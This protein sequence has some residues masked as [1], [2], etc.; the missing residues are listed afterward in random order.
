[1]AITGD[2]IPL[3][4]FTIMCLQ[5]KIYSGFF[6]NK[7]YLARMSGHFIANRMSKGRFPAF[8]Y[9]HFHFKIIQMTHTSIALVLFLILAVTPFFSNGVQ[10][11]IHYEAYPLIPFVGKAEF[12]DYLRI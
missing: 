3:C 2:A 9:I 12:A 4:N 1:M 11:Y 6:G 10:A 7:V 5:N 8:V